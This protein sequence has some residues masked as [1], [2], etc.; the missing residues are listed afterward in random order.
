MTERSPYIDLNRSAQKRW[1][2]QKQRE[3]IVEQLKAEQQEVQE[4]LEQ[5][6][7]NQVKSDN[8]NEEPT[9]VQQSYHDQQNAYLQNYIEHQKNLDMANYHEQDRS[10][11]VELSQ[12]NQLLASFNQQIENKEQV[13]FNHE[14]QIHHQV[15]E[16]QPI[17]IQRHTRP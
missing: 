8:L 16:V 17:E 3:Q 15:H 9:L 6:R 14:H 4:Q 10:Q 1:H 13:D 11:Q 2:W 7:T 12:V 5:Q